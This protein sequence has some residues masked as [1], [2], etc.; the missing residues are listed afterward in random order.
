MGN[1]N[2]IL[3]KDPK[4]LLSLY[5]AGYLAVP[6]EGIL[7]DAIYFSRYHLTSMVDDLKAPLKEQVVRALKTPLHRMITRVEARF[8][9]EEYAEE[10]HNDVLLELAK[11]DFNVLQSLHFEEMKDLSL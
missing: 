11:L 2:Q 3:A 4:G 1:F 10:H 5:N 8:Y 7:A 6:G 9:I